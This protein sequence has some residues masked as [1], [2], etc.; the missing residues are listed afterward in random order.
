MTRRKEESEKRFLEKSAFVKRE[1]ERVTG[2]LSRTRLGME[3]SFRVSVM[4][5]CA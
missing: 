4:T 5:R 2:S 1:R 3:G